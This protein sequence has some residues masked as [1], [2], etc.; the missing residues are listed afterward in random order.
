MHS[1]YIRKILP[2]RTIQG[3]TVV[4]SDRDQM[5]LNQTGTAIWN[6]LSEKTSVKPIADALASRFSSGQTS[7]PRVL[8]DVETFL[9]TLYQRGLVLKDGV[10]N[11]RPS[12][13]LNGSPEKSDSD[14]NA[15]TARPVIR[16]V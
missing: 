10:D 12:P 14:Q 7:F 6:L 5:F 4:L 11:P 16:S 2:Y 15:P 13:E 1:Q 8:F 9:E 3:Y